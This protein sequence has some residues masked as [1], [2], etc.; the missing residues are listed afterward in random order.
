MSTLNSENYIF[1]N[2]LLVLFILKETKSELTI[3]QIADLC[4]D[5]EDITYFD[6][7]QYID[8]LKKNNYIY[9][10]FQNNKSYYGLTDNGI[11]ILNELI[12]LVPGIN[13]LNITKMLKGQLEIYKNHYEIDTNIIPIK[14][15]EYKVGCY[16]KDGND[17]LINVSIYAGNIEN[18]R[19]ISNHWKENA[20]DIYSKIIEL[21]SPNN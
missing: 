2:K 17:E 11:I 15:D 7:C 19:N 8:E 1:D 3:E 21:M 16:I 12:E 20:N 5:F 13:L 9:E 4:S 6:F 10:S 18:A 14:A